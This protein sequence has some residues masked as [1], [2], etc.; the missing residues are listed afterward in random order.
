EA[1]RLTMQNVE[2]VRTQGLQLWVNQTLE[3]LGWT[4]GDVVL[5]AYT[6]PLNTWATMG[7]LLV[8]ENW[9]PDTVKSLHYFCGQMAGGIPPRDDAGAPEKAHGEVMANAEKF[10][11]NDLPKLWPGT[12]RLSRITSGPTSTP[13]NDTYSRWLDRRPGGC[14]RMSPGWTM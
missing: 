9:P 12:S 5:D 1:L 4:L 13:R 14:A 10:I 6:D 11:A 2:T 8:R 3:E 7:Q